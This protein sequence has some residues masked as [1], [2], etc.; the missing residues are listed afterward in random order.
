M[1]QKIFFLHFYVIVSKKFTQQTKII[2]KNQK[3]LQHLL[4]KIK[5]HDKMYTIS[6]VMAGR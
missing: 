5:K 6:W 3:K 4:T 1:Q 2:Q